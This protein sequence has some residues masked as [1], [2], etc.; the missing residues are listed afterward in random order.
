MLTWN[1]YLKVNGYVVRE[2]VDLYVMNV[3][4]NKKRKHEWTS[5]DTDNIG[6]Q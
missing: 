4:E 3:K 6:H 2:Q 5:R 1:F